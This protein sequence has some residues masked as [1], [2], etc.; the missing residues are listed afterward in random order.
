[1]PRLPVQ[2]KSC[3]QS[4]LKSCAHPPLGFLYQ[5]VPRLPVQLKSCRQSPLK[6]CA[7]LPLGFLQQFCRCR[8]R[9]S[10]L[11]HGEVNTKSCGDVVFSGRFSADTLCMT[12]TIVTHFSRVLSWRALPGLT[13]IHASHSLSNDWTLTCVPVGISTTF[14]I[15]LIS[16]SSRVFPFHSR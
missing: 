3:C 13:F 7:H 8:W 11:L 16:S 12:D 1:M 4:P 2:L 15:I 6:S 14:L 10:F 5:L 9:T